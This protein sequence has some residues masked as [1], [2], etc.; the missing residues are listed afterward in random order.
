[1]P[2]PTYAYTER[3]PRNWPPGSAGTG[4][5]RTNSTGSAM[6]S[7]T[8]TAARSATTGTGPQVMARPTQRRHRRAPHRRNHQHRRRHPPPRPRQQPPTGTTRLHLTTLP[9]HWDLNPCDHHAADLV[10]L[11]LSWYATVNCGAQ[12]GCSGRGAHVVFPVETPMILL[13]QGSETAGRT[14]LR[15]FRAM[16]PPIR[17]GSSAHR[18]VGSRSSCHAADAHC[19]GPG[20]AGRG[21][22]APSTVSRCLVRTSA[23]VK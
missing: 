4:T 23:V 19:R 2:S 11:Y 18:S 9:G 16:T 8:K 5:S 20:S 7:T 3:H 22:L 13:T 17:H 21:A 14:R 15:G 1:M 10:K 12:G 6:S